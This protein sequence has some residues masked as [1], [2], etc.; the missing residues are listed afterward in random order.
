MSGIGPK[1]DRPVRPPERNGRGQGTCTAT[2]QP[3]RRYR[4][5]DGTSLQKKCMHLNNHWDGL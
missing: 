3:A 5:V 1:T 2:L 4:Q